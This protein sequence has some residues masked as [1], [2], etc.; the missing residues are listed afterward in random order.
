M[1]EFTGNGVRGGDGGDAT[2]VALAASNCDNCDTRTAR[3]GTGIAIGGKGG[4]CSWYFLTTFVPSVEVLLGHITVT[5]RS[6]GGGGIGGD[7]TATG[8]KGSDGICNGCTGQKALGG[9]GGNAYANAGRGGYSLVGNQDRFRIVSGI[10]GDATA[11]GGGGGDAT[12]NADPDPAPNGCPG[13]NGCWTEAWAGDGGFARAYCWG[14]SVNGAKDTGGDGGT[15]TSHAGAGGNGNGCNCDG[16]PGGKAYAYGGNEGGGGG[17]VGGDANATGG[18][19][20]QGGDCCVPVS[21]DSGGDGGAGGQAEAH[22]GAQ[23]TYSSKGGS[24][25]NGGPAVSKPGRFGRRGEATGDV[26]GTATDGKDGTPGGLCPKDTSKFR[27]PL[28]EIIFD[29]ITPGQKYF[30]DLFSV[31][32][33]R[34]VGTVNVYFLT[35]SEFG[36]PVSYLVKGDTIV[37][38]Q[39][40]MKFSDPSFTNPNLAL[41]MRNFKMI[42]RLLSF[43]QYGNFYLRGVKGMTT[44]SEQQETV[45]IGDSGPYTLNIDAQPP[46]FFDLT[47]LGTNTPLVLIPGSIEGVFQP[48]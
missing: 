7:A 44:I 40:G 23:G 41:E 3:G 12:M 25:G 16:G 20:G 24:G 6:L 36:A 1:I 26:D 11:T 5:A 42:V 28:P 46:N 35:Q 29:L 32:S 22:A 21:G 34:V 27:V 4:G 30:S 37:L 17:A 33:Q 18:S 14:P 2:A 15:A 31:D 45:N 8:G 47:V 13:K 9:N 48:K 10:S 19:G 39:G 43:N 38:M